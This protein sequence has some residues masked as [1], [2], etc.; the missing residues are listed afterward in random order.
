MKLTETELK[1]GQMCPCC[2]QWAQMYKYS[3]HGTMA[4]AL[5]HIY[6]ATK[7]GIV[8]D[9]GYLHVEN[10]LVSLGEKPS[11]HGKL[12]Y[13]GLIEQKNNGDSSKKHSGEWRLTQKGL[14]FVEGRISVPRCAW[15]FNSQCYGFEGEE[16]FIDNISSKK[17]N[18]TKMMAGVA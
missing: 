7:N 17:F 15:L 10:Y 12:R 5:V 4:S 14:D 2:T 8:D 18:Y 11:K 16:V 6:I 9:E 1:K 3:F 13:W